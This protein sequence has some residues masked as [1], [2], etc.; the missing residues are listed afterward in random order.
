MVCLC[1]NVLNLG[2]WIVW[3][4]TAVYWAEFVTTKCWVHNCVHYTVFSWLNVVTRIYMQAVQ[5]VSISW[6]CYSSIISNVINYSPLSTSPRPRVQKVI[7]SCMDRGSVSG[8]SR[9]GFCSWSL[10]L[11]AHVWMAV[12]QSQPKDRMHRHHPSAAASSHLNYRCAGA[13]QFLIAFN[14]SCHQLPYTDTPCRLKHTTS[15][16]VS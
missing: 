6:R 8:V 7:V 9:D 13:W 15:L 14:R 4:T 3:P 16:R 10:K 12:W 1:D 5:C 11:L 2:Q